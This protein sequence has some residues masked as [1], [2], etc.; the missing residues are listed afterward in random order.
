MFIEHLDV[1]YLRDIATALDRHF[2]P[3]LAASWDWVGL[4]VG[5]LEEPL[6]GVYIALDPSPDAIQRTIDAGCNLL[7]THHPLYIRAPKRFDFNRGPGEAIA[8]ALAQRL[9]IYA[10]HTNLDA[11]PGGLNDFLS[12][13]L[14]LLDSTPLLATPSAAAFKLVTF[15]PETAASA[16]LDALFAAGAGEIG[17]Y[18]ACS[19]RQPG[20][21]TFCGNAQTHPAIGKAGAFTEAH[22]LRIEVWVDAARRRPVEEALLAKHPYEEV[23]FDWIPLTAPTTVKAKAGL[24]RIGRLPKPLSLSTCLKEWSRLLKIPHFRVVEPKARRAKAVSRVALCSGS[25][26]SLLEQAADAGADLFI[27][28][29]MK[30]HDALEAQALGLTVVDFGHFGT[31]HWAVD[32]LAKIVEIALPAARQAFSKSRS[33]PAIHRDRTATDPFR[34]VVPDLRPKPK[35]C[36]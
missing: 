35:E 8:L 32:L 33:G 22:E 26:A 34:F 12:N 6:K 3:S 17:D 25:G 14:G 23:A 13:R 11:A 24:G 27:T 10:V 29:D 20:T 30:Y 7:L 19:F 36:P 15:V 18:R 16:V 28:G 4:Q 1:L 2:P 9:S 5:S 31:E 21:G